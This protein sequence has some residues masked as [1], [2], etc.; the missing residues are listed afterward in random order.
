MPNSQTE[1]YRVGQ[2]G[3]HLVAAELGRRGVVCSILS[4]N[5]PE[6]D[7]LAFRNGK[8]IAVQVKAIRSGSMHAR[9]DR[10]LEIKMDGYRQIVLG[11]KNDIDRSMAFVVVFLGENAGEDRFYVLTHGDLQDQIEQ[12]HR[13]FLA[14]HHGVRPKNPMSMHTGV[15]EEQLSK[16]I[17]CW[18]TILTHLI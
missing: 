8:S 17:G 1:T 12:N 9:A 18:D 16:F 13:V 2:T 10:Y 5:A 4:G 3:E 11:K 14:R 7:I 15:S 6:I